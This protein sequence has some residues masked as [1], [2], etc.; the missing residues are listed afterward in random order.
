[1]SDKE[2]VEEVINS[3]Y[4]H[5][6]QQNAFIDIEPFNNLIYYPSLPLAKQIGLVKQ[7]PFG[8]NVLC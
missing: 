1:M 6:G 5:I 8:I 2:I 3:P 4:N 7:L